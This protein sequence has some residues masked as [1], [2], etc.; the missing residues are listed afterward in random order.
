M[1]WRSLEQLRDRPWNAACFYEQSLA[2]AYDVLLD[3][4]ALKPL[5][6]LASVEPGGQRIRDAFRKAEQRQ[7]PDMRA[8]WFNKTARQMAMRTSPDEFLVAKQGR[9]GYAEHLWRKRSHLLLANRMRLNLTQTPAAFS[10]EPILGSAFVPAS[11]RTGNRRELSKAWCVWF[12]STFGVIAF[13][14]T[15]QKNLTYPN[16]SLEGLR[17]LPAPCPDRCDT[18]ALAT[19]FEDCSDDRLQPLPRIHED[20]VR[21]ALD[22]A[23]LTAVPGLPT[24]DLA[25][26]RR[27]IAL[28]PSVNNEKDPFRLSEAY[29]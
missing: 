17:S 29:T 15:R 9:Q 8:L 4:P 18:A 7:S 21:R 5:G 10:D 22:D 27:A 13:L 28:E 6:E 2:E 26:W 19:A 20:P 14:N 25:D 16:F 12:N 23:V 24:G 1:A 11:P 3:C